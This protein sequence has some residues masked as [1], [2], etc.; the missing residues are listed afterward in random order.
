MLREIA[1]SF[2]DLIKRFVD[3]DLLLPVG[4]PLAEVELAGQFPISE[5]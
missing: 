2:L 4:G 3:L 1:S 5:M